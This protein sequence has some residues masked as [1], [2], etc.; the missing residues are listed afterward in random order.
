VVGHI[1][2]LF[3]SQHPNQNNACN[4]RNFRKLRAIYLE[5]NGFHILYFLCVAGVVGLC[6]EV[7][8][9]LVG[10]DS[11]ST[12]WIPGTESGYQA[13]GRRLDPLSC[14]WP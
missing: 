11:L 4:F 9:Q 1:Q 10:T 3:N 12:T 2:R 5:Y 7:R 14:L 13:C 6:V 8:E